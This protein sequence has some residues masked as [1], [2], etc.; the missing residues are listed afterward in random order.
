MRTAGA[1][2][3]TAATPV[4]NRT[5]AQ[6]AAAWFWAGD[7]NG[8]YKPPGQMLQTT[9]E[10]A[11]ARGLGVYANVRLFA[12]VSIVLADTGIAVRDAKL[13]GN[14]TVGVVGD[15][16]IARVGPDRTEQALARPEARP[17]TSPA[18]RCAAGSP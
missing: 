16:L 10:V 11:N 3:P 12:L 2:K 1:D 9:R 6:L 17:M 8:T 14:M 15:E 18:V 5:P 13:R 4:I 7:N